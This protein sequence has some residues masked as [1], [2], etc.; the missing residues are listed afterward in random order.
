V[1]LKHTQPVVQEF[2]L[3]DAADASLHS[4]KVAAEDSVQSTSKCGSAEN[5]KAT[6][7]L[8]RCMS[9]L[10]AASMPLEISPRMA[11]KLRNTPAPSAQSNTSGLAAR[12]V[13]SGAVLFVAL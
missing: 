8:A 5:N 7:I 13:S 2:I 10:S 6:I 3:G 9:N 12:F 1:V 4:R 11:K